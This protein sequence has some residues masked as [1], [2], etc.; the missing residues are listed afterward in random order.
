MLRIQ[1][2]KK[3]LLAHNPIPNLNLKKS[4]ILHLS[5]QYESKKLSKKSKGR[6]KGDPK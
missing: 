5:S 4:Y 6:K 2:K 1:L 3:N